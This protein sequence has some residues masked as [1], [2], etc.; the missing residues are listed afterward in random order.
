MAKKQEA[1]PAKH[2]PSHGVFVVEGD[3]DRAYWTK[4]GCAWAHNDGQ[5]FNVQLSAIP[6]GG[7]LIIRARK[8]GEQ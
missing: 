5:G 3:G 4:I 8:D 1:A 2:T 7:R 6:V